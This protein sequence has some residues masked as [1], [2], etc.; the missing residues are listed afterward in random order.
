MSTYI[1]CISG[2]AIGY[3][4]DSSRSS[5]FSYKGPW[6]EEGRGGKE[7]RVLFASSAALLLPGGFQHLQAVADLGLMLSTTADSTAPAALAP[8]ISTCSTCKGDQLTG[9]P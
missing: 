5:Q 9:P 7:A 1:G 3:I 4:L 2:G 8:S 6:R